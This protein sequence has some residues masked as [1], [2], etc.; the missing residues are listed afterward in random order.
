MEEKI[1]QFLSAQADILVLAGLLMLVVLAA[2]QL[3]K[4]SRLNRQLTRLTDKLG[5][6]L[7]A[8]LA[9]EPEELDEQEETAVFVSAQEKNMRESLEQQKR[10]NRQRDAQVFDA[11]LSEIYP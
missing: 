7:Q 1:I 8:V 9:D 5:G 3:A 6:Y 2:L 4:M 10:K 11:V